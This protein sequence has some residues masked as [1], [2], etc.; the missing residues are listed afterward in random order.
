M[1]FDLV[2]LEP[3]LLAASPHHVT[4]DDPL[5]PHFMPGSVA[6]AGI[7]LARAL[8]PPQLAKIRRRGRQGPIKRLRCQPPL[9]VRQDP[10]QPHIWG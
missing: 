10:P 1:V 9:L 4:E 2:L 5:P 6:G 8:S 7:S 3:M